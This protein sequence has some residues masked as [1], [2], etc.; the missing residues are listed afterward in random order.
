MHNIANKPW[1]TKKWTKYMWRALEWN[2]LGNSKFKFSIL[3][4]FWA[5][6]F[7]YRWKT[8]KTDTSESI[9]GVETC[10]KCN[11]RVSPQKYHIIY[12]SLD[13]FLQIN[14]IP[15]SKTFKYTREVCIPEDGI[16]IKTQL[17]FHLFFFF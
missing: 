11:K 4:M 7:F 3:K 10:E 17:W 15:S 13:T 12:T 6:F 9:F 8:L 1:N 14:I 16:D 5:V 2:S